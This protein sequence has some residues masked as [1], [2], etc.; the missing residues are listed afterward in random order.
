MAIDIKDKIVTIVGLGRSGIASAHLALKL[1]AKVKISDAA[2]REKIREALLRANLDDLSLIESGQHTKEFIQESD[3]VVLS[4]GVA[5]NA[6]PAFWARERNIPVLGEIEF[7]WQYC[8]CDVVAVT[9]T[10]G[11]TT[12][13]TVIAEILKASGRNAFL[14]G[15]I[16]TP[17]SQ[18]V[19]D[20][21]KNDIV[22]LEVSSFQLETIETFKPKVAVFLNF[23]QNH[24]DRHQDLNE[25]FTAKARIF[26][27]QTRNDFAVLNFYEPLHRD[28]AAKLS[29]HI[30]YYNE[31]GVCDPSVVNPNFLAAIAACSVLGV[32]VDVAKRFL[33]TFKGVEHRQEFVRT[34]DGV[35]YVNDSKST[36]VESGRLA[37]MLIQKPLIFICG[38]RNKHLD[39]S[40]LREIARE[41]IKKMIV[42]GQ[43]KEDLKHAFSDILPLEEGADLEDAVCKARAAAQAGDCVVLSPMCVSFDMFDNFEHRGREFKRIVHQL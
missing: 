1:G 15:N 13:T 37:M 41:K 9:G 12:T 29:S 30:L 28:L 33:A 10:N 21:K 36:T 43:D 31:P 35:D 19:L 27:N 23:S 22:A 3:V 24:L 34:L 8:P 11:K 32:P 6:L 38:G 26:M 25:Y 16:G 20:L 4:P 14:C 5:V 39:F 18:Y 2:P 17:F 7:A 42:F 40:S